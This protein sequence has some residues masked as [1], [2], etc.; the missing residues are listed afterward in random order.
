MNDVSDLSSGIYLE[1]RPDVQ[2]RQPWDDD[3][4]FWEDPAT[5]RAIEELTIA[6]G[7]EAADPAQREKS[8]GVGLP[9]TNPLCD[10]GKRSSGKS[11]PSSS[12]SKTIT[13]TIS[14]PSKPLQSKGIHASCQEVT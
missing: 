2:T 9:P 1:S 12:S 6:E 8:K 10:N 11:T 14:R 3:P 13:A 5:L 4:D 7:K